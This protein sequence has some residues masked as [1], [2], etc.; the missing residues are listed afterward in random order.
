[1]PPLRPA[2]PCPPSPRTS[3]SSLPAR[4]SAPSTAA[5]LLVVP[6][7]TH[8]GGTLVGTRHKRAPL[9]SPAANQASTGSKLPRQ[10]LPP[11]HAADPGAHHQPNARPAVPQLIYGRQQAHSRLPLVLRVAG[12]AGGRQRIQLIQQQDA[13]R[14]R[15]GCSMSGGVGRWGV[16]GGGGAGGGRP[17]A[18][19]QDISSR[20]SGHQQ[21]LHVKHCQQATAETG[22]E[23][24][25]VRCFHFPFDPPT[26]PAPLP[27]PSPALNARL[28][29]RSP[30]SP[31][32]SPPSTTTMGRRASAASA[33]ARWVLPEP[34]GGRVVP[35]VAAWAQGCA[36]WLEWPPLSP[37][38]H[39]PQGSTSPSGAHRE[40]R[41]AARRARRAPPGAQ[42]GGGGPAGTPQLPPAPP[43]GTPAHPPQQTQ[44]RWRRP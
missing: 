20:T 38:Q 25:R 30:F 27:P 1:M 26:R 10:Q 41:A 22:N 21:Q 17:A 3:V 24:G 29:L 15:L 44:R 7:Y 42:R 36:C 14:L 19:Y 32:H 23:A 33:R 28:R 8:E 40:G 35:S 34:A 2:A 4:R 16:A 9:A 39:C 18:G 13:G 12:G 31:T 11:V 6:W 43:S 5:R 37:P